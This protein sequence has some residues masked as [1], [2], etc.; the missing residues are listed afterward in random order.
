MQATKLDDVKILP[1]RIAL[2]SHLSP[3]TSEQVM[4]L[5]YN[6]SCWSDHSRENCYQNRFTTLVARV[7]EEILPDFDHFALS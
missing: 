3:K 6:E 4:H 2:L 7:G 5:K 1:K